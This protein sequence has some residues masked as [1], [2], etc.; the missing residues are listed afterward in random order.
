[1]SDVITVHIGESAKKVLDLISTRRGRPYV[2]I[3]EDGCCSFSNVFVR[4]E[5]PAGD[6]IKLECSDGYEVYIRDVIAPL[7]QGQELWLHALHAIDDS[8]SAETEFGFKIT[9]S[10]GE[11]HDSE[12]LQ[13][14]RKELHNT[15]K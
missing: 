10:Y 13:G 9:L 15:H 5:V 8:F 14:G 7:Y 6:F 12:W 2:T 11:P 3:V 4:L 1:V